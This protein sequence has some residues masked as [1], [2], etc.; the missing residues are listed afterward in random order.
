[1]FLNRFISFRSLIGGLLA[2]GAI[3]FSRTRL[4]RANFLIEQLNVL[5]RNNTVCGINDTQVT[6]IFETVTIH[7]GT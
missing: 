2:F 6:S 3:L 7:L 1:M 5:S 4:I